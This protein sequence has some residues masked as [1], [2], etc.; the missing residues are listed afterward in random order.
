MDSWFQI[1]D[2]GFFCQW[3]LDSGIQSLAGFRVTWAGIANSKAQDS[4]CHKQKFPNSGFLKQNFLDSGNQIP[5]HVA[6]YR[7][8][9]LW[10][11]NENER[12]KQKQQTNGNGTIW[13]VYRTDT[14]ERGFWLVTR[15][16]RW[17]N[18]MPE[19]VLEINRYFALTSYCNT[20]GQS[21]KAISILGF[22][23]RENEESMFWSFHPL[24]DKTNNEHLPKP[25]F[26]VT[27]K[28]L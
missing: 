5:L 19:N 17:K 20:N 8:I 3:N 6:R 1:L 14:N 24:A 18:F 4:R 22:L 12:T 13:L 28:S 26:K 27:R 21:S 10:P 7:A 9:C 25:F 23:W 15:T 16:L 11:R 2:S